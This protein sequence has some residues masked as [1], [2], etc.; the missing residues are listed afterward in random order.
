M[1]SSTGMVGSEGKMGQLID[2]VVSEKSKAT[3]TISTSTAF[4]PAVLENN[5]WVY[6][7]TT[8]IFIF[9]ET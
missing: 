7:N 9:E 4:E 6:S 2:G 3:I 1:V 5:I 8:F